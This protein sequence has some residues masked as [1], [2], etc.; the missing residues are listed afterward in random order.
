MS[1]FEENQVDVH[2][3]LNF[4]IVNYGL[5]IGQELWQ[6]QEDENI[7]KIVSVGQFFQVIDK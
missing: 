7:L 3:Y 1:F 6:I 5:V 4:W 2:K